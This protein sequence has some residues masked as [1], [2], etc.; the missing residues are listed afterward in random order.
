MDLSRRQFLRAGAGSGVFVALGGAGAILAACSKAT[1]TSTP[2]TTGSADLSKHLTISMIGWGGA[3]DPIWV[4]PLQEKLNITINYKGVSSMPEL[5]QLLRSAPPGTYDIAGIY[6]HEATPILVAADRLEPLNPADYAIDSLIEWD[7]PSAE[8]TRGPEIIDGKLYYLRSHTDYQ[9]IIF[10]TDKVPQDEILS[11]GY[12]ILYDPKYTGRIITWDDPTQT[13]PLMGFLLGVNPYDVDD[14]TWNEMV[15]KLLAL[16]KQAVIVPS[17]GE[18]VKALA[19]GSGDILGTMQGGA[20]LPVLKGQ[21]IN[22][23]VYFDKRGVLTPSE[24][25]SIIKGTGNL[26][27]AKL[28]IQEWMTPQIQAFVVQKAAWA[29]P[30]TAGAAWQLLPQSYLDNWAVTYD[31]ATG[32]VVPKLGSPDWTLVDWIAPIRPT[33]DV[34]LEAWQQYKSA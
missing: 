27:R 2:Q 17:A 18:G 20:V 23:A 32:N 10:N 9:G 14:A 21:G 3:P 1:T 34:W 6:N 13:I 26:E 16:K 30:P 29:S 8:R 28:F 19:Q 5:E 15:A 11:K 24:G 31:S 25:V 22:A 12:D 4:D 33:I 7:R